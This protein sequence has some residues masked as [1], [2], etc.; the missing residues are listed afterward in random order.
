MTTATE[1]RP[2]YSVRNASGAPKV[3]IY[4]TIGEGG[5]E[6]SAFVSAFNRIT[7]PAIDLYVNSPGGDPF[8]AL[9]IHNAIQRHKAS[10]TTIVDGVAASAASIIVQAG[11]RRVM[12]KTAQMMIHQSS[13]MTLGQSEAHEKMAEILA[14][15][16]DQIAGVYAARAG[17]TRE[18]WR[19]RM[20]EESWYDAQEAVAVGLADEITQFVS[21]NAFTTGRVFNL[22]QFKK[23]PATAPRIVPAADRIAALQAQLNAEIRAQLDGRGD[24]GALEDVQ[25]QLAELGR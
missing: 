13:G 20:R 10:V 25:R 6:A 11:D 15:I 8:T 19:Q 2:W 24:R 5:V 14:R 4:D 21:A 12:A 1:A 9:A 7:S 22:S 16:D 18:Q 23:R 17:G 3:Y